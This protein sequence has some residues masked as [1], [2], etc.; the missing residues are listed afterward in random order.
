MYFLPGLI[1][2]LCLP[3]GCLSTWDL[4]VREAMPWGTPCFPL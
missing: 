1:K 3:L 2:L 4:T